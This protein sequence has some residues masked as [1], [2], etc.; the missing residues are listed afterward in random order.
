LKKR[1]DLEKVLPNDFLMLAG[2][3]FW[4]VVVVVHIGIPETFDEAEGDLFNLLR[5]DQTC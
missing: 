4:I 1:V 2:S 3:T 5:R